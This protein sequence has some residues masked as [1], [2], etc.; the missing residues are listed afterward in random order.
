M[1]VTTDETQEFTPIFVTWP[2][3]LNGAPTGGFSGRGTIFRGE[4]EVARSGTWGNCRTQKDLSAILSTWA[5]AEIVKL[6]EA[7]R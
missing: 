6:M 7:P 2:T 3:K 1:T 5:D 4:E